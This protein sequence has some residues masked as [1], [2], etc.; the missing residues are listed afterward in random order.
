MAA[1]VTVPSKTL[2]V[3]TAEKNIPSHETKGYLPEET[4]RL[5]ESVFLFNN[6]MDLIYCSFILSGCIAGFLCYVFVSKNSIV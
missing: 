2:W 1:A 3:N 6:L 4:K 5:S